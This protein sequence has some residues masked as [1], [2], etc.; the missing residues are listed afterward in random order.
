MK[1]RVYEVL[2]AAAEGDGL[3]RAFD[4]FLVTLI[5][6]NIA[7]MI[8]E[9]VEA[10]RNLAPRFFTW[11]EIVSVLLFSIEYLLRVWSCTIAAPY[12]AP[13]TGRLRYMATPLAVVDLL[14]VLPFYLPFVG[15]D[16]RS[17]RVLRLFRLIRIAKLARYSEALQ[18]TG[19][20]VKSRRTELV[21]T[22]FILLV[23]MLL[24]SSLMYYAEHEAQPDT[25]SS[26]PAAM[27]WAVATLSTVGYGDV[28]PVTLFGKLL[29][30][31]IAV[32]GIGM[33]A[34]P[35]GILGAAFVEE[36]QRTR[37]AP[38][39]CPHCGKELSDQDGS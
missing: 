39:H 30:S 17:F 32:L 23:L 10:C 4:I 16:L 15:V 28:Y 20:V 37:S 26:M 21:T 13:V 5:A 27:W 3:S 2:A 1:R 14:A 18:L 35:T 8:M 6:L 25:F 19:R 33:F 38:K 7:A 12:R 9:T 31:A 34:L 22:I 29:A 24:A 11:F 36:I